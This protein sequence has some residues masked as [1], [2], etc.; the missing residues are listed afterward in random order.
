MH[1]GETRELREQLRHRLIAA[2]LHR[3]R[4]LF[5]MD[6]RILLRLDGITEKV[7]ERRN[8]EA[9][10]LE[11]LGGRRHVRPLGRQRL[12]A[13]EGDEY[14]LVANETLAR[15]PIARRH[16]V[17]FGVVDF[18]GTNTFQNVPGCKQVLPRPP[19][20]QSCPANPACP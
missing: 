7:V 1:A 5:V 8:L 13:F 17:D 12:V 15:Q 9:A 2:F 14:V 6:R 16:V 4:H 11:D 20:P 18:L 19:A 3:R 10:A